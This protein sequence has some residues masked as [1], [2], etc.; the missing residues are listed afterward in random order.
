[1]KAV[2]TNQTNNKVVL[3]AYLV[4]YFVWGSTF[5]F[6]HKALSDFTP[7]VLGSLRFFAASMILLTYCKMRGYKIF[8]KQVVKQACIT[9][10]LLL[11]IDM[12]S[13]NLG[14][15]TRIKWYC[16]YYGRSSSLMVHHFR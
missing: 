7:F 8:N 9:G 15:A 6:I 10:F 5:F 3:G 14:R 13:L 12:G 2:A 4:V 16:S 1:M 11:F